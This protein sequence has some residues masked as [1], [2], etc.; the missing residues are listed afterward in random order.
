MTRR[1]GINVSDHAL[2]RLLERAGAVDVEAL[3]RAVATSIGRAVLVAESIG[4]SEFV[5]V[6]DGLSYVVKNGVVTTVFPEPRR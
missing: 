1:S 4:A 5:I 3:R 2:L 6:A